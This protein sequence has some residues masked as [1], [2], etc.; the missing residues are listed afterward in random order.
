[1]VLVPDNLIKPINQN[2]SYVKKIQ[3]IC[4]NSNHPI[5][6][7]DQSNNHIYNGHTRINDKNISNDKSYNELNSL[8]QLN[9]MELN[10]IVDQGYKILLPMGSS[11]STK[12]SVN[13]NGTTHISTFLKNCF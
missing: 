1:M 2:K 5:V 3:I 12:L 6:Q 13:H 11:K 8:P 10:M 4:F 9:G 7:D